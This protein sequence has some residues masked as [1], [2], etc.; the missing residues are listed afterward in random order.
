[1]S[2]PASLSR[3][4]GRAA[5]LLRCRRRPSPCTSP[6][7]SC[8]AS[9][10]VLWY[11]AALPFVAWGLRDLRRRSEEPPWFKPLVGLVGAAVFLI[12]CMP[13]PVPTAGTCS[14]PCGTGIAAILIGPGLTVVVA[15]IALTLQALFLAHGGLTTLGANIVSMGVAGAYVGYGVY[16]DRP[17]PGA[18]LVRRGLPGGAALRLGHLRDDLL[19]TGRRPPRRGIVFTTMFSLI[20]LAFVPTQ[21]PL[22]ILEGFLCAGALKFIRSRKTGTPP[23]GRGGRHGMKKA[24]ADPDRSPAFLLAG[25]SCPPGRAASWS[26]VDE[27]VIEKFA[28]KAGR[29]A[30]EPFIN[31]D[32]GDLLL[33]VFLLAGIVGGFIGGYY[34]RVLFPAKAQHRRTKS[35]FDLFSDIFTYRDN[36]LTRIDPRVKLLIALA[37]LIAVV[38][39]ERT[40]LPLARLRASAS[41]PSRPSGSRRSSSRCR[42]AAPLSIV[43]VLVVIQTF[44]TGTTPLFAFTLGGWTLTAKAEGLRQG[45]LLGARVLGAVSH[46]PSPEHRHAG[47]PDLP[48]APLVPDLPELAGDRDPHVPLHLRPDGP[49]GGSRRGPEAAPGIHGAGPRAH[50]LRG[51]RRGDARPFA[52]TGPAD[53]RRDAAARLPG[54]DALRAAPGPERE[55]PQDPAPSALAAIAAARLLEWGMGG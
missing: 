52:R 18:P 22:G 30:R 45:T 53:A 33:F 31:T 43:A 5:L 24:I 29:P 40:V 2:S 42:L 4:R 20:L 1:M 37:A 6:R 38:T 16:A 36:A 49:R 15:S 17:A 8:P 10:A 27:T 12:S 13:I 35:M 50:L 47:A 14:H 32:Q 48:G 54:D 28:E 3:D 34:F 44:V 9:W 25:P 7:G 46:R 39:A 41:A 51:A 23:D 11:A 55:G 21:L 26:G 19:R